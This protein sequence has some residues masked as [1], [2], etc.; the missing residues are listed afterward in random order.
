MAVLSSELSRTSALNAT[1]R[2]RM[3]DLMLTCYDGMDRERFED[4]LA[5]KDEVIL[6]YDEPGRLHGFST[7]KELT[8]DVSGRTVRGIFSGD[9]VI[10]PE[11]WGSGELFRRFAQTY[12]KRAES[13]FEE[14]GETLYWFLIS[15]G[16]RTYRILPTFYKTFYPN[17]KAETPTK[18]QEVMD[19]Y[20]I[21]LF[22][23]DYAEVDGVLRYK[24]SKD[25]LRPGI[26][27]PDAGH[28]R[29]PDVR[30]FVEKNPGWSLGHDLVCITSLHPDNLRFPERMLK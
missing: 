18:V 20:A 14:T 4:D 9:T 24:E 2:D 13:L 8:V 21:Q 11:A 3:F 30:F 1:T 15:K 10:S 27:E 12:C 22:G 23:N 19:A 26:A 29:Q 7:Q 16:Q 6:L 5:D 17:R 25:T 28:L